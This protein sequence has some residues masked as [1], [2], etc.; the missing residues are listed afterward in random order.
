MQ[1][2]NDEDQETGKSNANLLNI[3]NAK[4]KPQHKETI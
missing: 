4:F 1:T 2:L 3:V